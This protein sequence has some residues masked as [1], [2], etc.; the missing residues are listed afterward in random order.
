VQPGLALLPQRTKRAGANVYRHRHQSARRTVTI[1]TLCP[2]VP[3]WRPRSRRVCLA[4]APS[5]DPLRCHLVVRRPTCKPP[6][7]A[8]C[9]GTTSSWTRATP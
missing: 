7:R 1:L 5:L 2:I 3:L 6:W 8:A 4:S 9:G